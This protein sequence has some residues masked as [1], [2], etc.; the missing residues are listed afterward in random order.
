MGNVSLSERQRRAVEVPANKPDDE[1]ACPECG[2]KQRS[3]IQCA[4]ECANRYSEQK[5]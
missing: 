3:V 1:W 5:E 2:D 4:I